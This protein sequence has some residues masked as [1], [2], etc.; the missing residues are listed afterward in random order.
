[1][2]PPGSSFREASSSRRPTKL[3]QGGIELVALI[4]APE[5]LWPPASSLIVSSLRVDTLHL[6][7]CCHPCHLRAV[8]SSSIEKIPLAA[9]WTPAAQACRPA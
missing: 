8:I 6:G 5:K 2:S 9:L 3:V 7:K 1:M 4:A